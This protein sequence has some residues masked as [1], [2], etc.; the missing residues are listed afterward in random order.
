MVLDY[1]DFEELMEEVTHRFSIANT[2]GLLQDILERLDWS[3][4][5]SIEEEPL[6]TFSHG[7]ILVI[8][9]QTVPVDKLRTTVNKLGLDISR[10]E[11][12]LGYEEAQ[13]FNYKKL[14]YNMNYRVVLFGS[15]PHSTIGTGSSSSVIAEM[16]THPDKYPRVVPLRSGDGTLKIT[17]SD[18]KNALELLKDEGYIA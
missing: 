8:G 7:K 12:H 3:D 2:Q 1:I 5:L 13:T 9:E 11:F 4:L 10:F 18:F 14:E 6:K 16:Q 17:K 15:I